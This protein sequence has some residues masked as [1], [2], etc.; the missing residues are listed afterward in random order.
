MNWP[1]AHWLVGLLTLILF[2]LTG[3]Y[4]LHIAGVPS[5]DTV[6]RLIFRSRHLFLLVAAVAN[7]AL[8]STIPVLRVQKVAGILVMVAPL[9][10]AAAFF[11]DPG[12][13]VHS[14]QVFHFAMYGIFV[15]G[16]LLAVANRP[17]GGRSN[18]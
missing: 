12:R 5:L 4:M 11:T 8:S 10:L 13:G 17:G 3:Q 1:R 2:P 9:L 15:A 18:P 7:L 14:S 16:V 6:P